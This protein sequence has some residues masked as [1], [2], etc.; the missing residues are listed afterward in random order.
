[1]STQELAVEMMTAQRAKRL[2]DRSRPWRPSATPASSLG[3]GCDRHLVYQ[4]MW[5]E[6]AA[7]ISEELASIFTEGNIH[8]TQVRTELVELGY[9][10][11]EAEV[12]FR[13][14]RLEISGTIDGK[15]SRQG[16]PAHGGPRRI[17]VEIKSWGGDGPTCVDEMDTRL[18]KKYFAQMQTYL[19]LTEQPDGLMLFKSKMTGLWSVFPVELDYE[20]GEELFQTAERVRD[21]V[22]RIKAAKEN[23]CNEAE[24][25]ELL[26]D[27]C[28]DRGP[29][30][31]CQF[32]LHCG[33]AE[34]EVDPL[35]L[36]Q[37]ADLLAKLERREEL[38]QGRREFAKLD[39]GIKE[40]F[41]LTGGTRFVVGGATGFLVEKKVQKN[42]T[43]ILISRLAP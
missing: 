28:L 21:A 11:V 26:P 7:P 16:D 36:A 6:L 18:M 9:E 3:V 13:D 33:P 19:L 24:L 27:R 25:F 1:M 5:P 35:L 34:A 23:G 17:P 4:R 20:R 32:R 22:R 41:K 37:D 8:Q 30:D 14:D 42:G 39:D 10:V 15:I 2:K 38:D 12:N 40:R 29:C 43:R 31:S